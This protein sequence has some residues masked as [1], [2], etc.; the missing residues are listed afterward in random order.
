MKNEAAKKMGEPRRVHLR[1][2][3]WPMNAAKMTNC[4]YRDNTNIYEFPPQAHA[5]AGHFTAPSSHD[6]YL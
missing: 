6:L 5:S 3:G 1:T 4:R 2:Y